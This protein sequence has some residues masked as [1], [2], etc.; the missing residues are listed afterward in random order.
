MQGGKFGSEFVSAGLTE[1]F[2]PIAGQLSDAPYARALARGVIGG[3]ISELTGDN[4]ANGAGSAVFAELFNH[5]SG[6]DEVDASCDEMCEGRR[7]RQR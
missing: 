4:F 5:L 2:S 6:G 3:T 1:T 7:D